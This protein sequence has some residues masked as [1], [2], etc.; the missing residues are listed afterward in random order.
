MDSGNVRPKVFWGRPTIVS[1]YT[2]KLKPIAMKWWL[3]GW[4]P[5]RVRQIGVKYAQHTETPTTAPW[6]CQPAPTRH[7]QTH[8][9]QH[10]FFKNNLLS[11][12][13]A[14]ALKDVENQS[15]VWKQG[16]QITKFYSRNKPTGQPAAAT[17][18]RFQGK[19]T[20]NNPSCPSSKHQK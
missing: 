9:L 13:G 5:T 18:A 15:E 17:L 2:A 11:P 12:Q 1:S 10:P 4:N 7:W 14:N 3:Q 6:Q 20:E 8:V 19:T 16:L